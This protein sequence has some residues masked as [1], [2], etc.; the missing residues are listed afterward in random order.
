[1]KYM[2]KSIIF[3]VLGYWNCTYACYLYKETFGTP[4]LQRLVLGPEKY[5]LL[6]IQA[7]N[8]DCPYYNDYLTC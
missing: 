7:C 8:S 6:A 5:N 2:L 4:G 3:S 1:M